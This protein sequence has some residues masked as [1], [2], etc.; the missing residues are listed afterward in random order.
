MKKSLI[1]LLVI[2]VAAAGGVYYANTLAE[3]AI[4][5]QFEQA[6][7]S[8][9]DMAELGEAPEIS[10]AYT[11]ISANVLTSSYSISGMSFS[12][13]EMGTVATIDLIQA[14]GLKPQSLS[15]KGSA[16]VTGIKAAPALL[17][18]LPPHASAYLQGLALHGE[19]NYAYNDTGELIFTQQTRINDEFAF[20]YSFSFAQM[21]QLWQ[22]A[23]EMSAMSPEQQQALVAD[24][25]YINNM[26]EKLATGAVKDGSITIE[27]NGFIERTLAMTAEQGQTPDFATVQGLALANIAAIEQIP[28][29][30]KQSLSDFISKPAKLTL[31]FGFTE[32]LQFAKVQSGELAE[33]M[34]SPEAMIKFA[35][36]KLQA[37]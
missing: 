2:G 19:Y 28:A 8:Y 35:N 26:L 17:Q 18:M 25:A 22:F 37:N 11:D 30:M 21:Q 5:Q 1:A 4:K 31:S 36:V 9:R 27:N 14:K 7:Q 10:M 24:E 15:D 29:D 12:L 13:G 34:A 3:D 20:N 33:Q 16:T 23:R 32:P 6:N